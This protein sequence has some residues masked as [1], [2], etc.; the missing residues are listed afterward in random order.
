MGTVGAYVAGALG[1]IALYLILSDGGQSANTVLTGASSFNTN[2]I[3]ALQ[4]R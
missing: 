1:L 4:G 2:A 3:K